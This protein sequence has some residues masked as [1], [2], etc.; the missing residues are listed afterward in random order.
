[1]HSLRLSMKYMHEKI[2]MH[3]FAI[4]YY[5]PDKHKTETKIR[6]AFEKYS[7]K[8]NKVAKITIIIEKMKTK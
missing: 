1:M 4:F 8:M 6:K 5:K 2:N 3:S 7:G